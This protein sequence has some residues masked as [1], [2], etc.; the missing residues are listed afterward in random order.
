VPNRYFLK[1]IL[2]WSRKIGSRFCEQT[3]DVKKPAPP[4]LKTTPQPTKHGPPLKV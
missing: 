2:V 4:F 1:L 3:W